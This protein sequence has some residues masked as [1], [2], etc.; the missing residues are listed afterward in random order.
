MIKN[1]DIDRVEEELSRKGITVPEFQRQLGIQSQHWNNWKK[2]GIPGNRIIDIANRLD[3]T[4]NWISTGNKTYKNKKEAS[5]PEIS[6][7]I[8]AYE[9]RQLAEFKKI[10][11]VGTA[12]LGDNAHWTEIDYPAGFGDGAL[13]YP[14][15]D[16]NAYALRCIGDSMKPRIKDG[17]FV[18]IEPNTPPIPGDE[19]LI[20]S[21]DGRVM[22]KTFLYEREGRIYLMSVNELHPPQS[23]AREEIEKIHHVAAIVK[24]ALF[25]CD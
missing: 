10:P 12:Q 8:N 11:V 15:N 18:I 4:A 16:Q 23:F 21:I 1:S 24:K 14:S 25:R 7:N 2:R 20:K 17:E 19:V 22:V 5:K 3:I 13:K 9:V 6:S